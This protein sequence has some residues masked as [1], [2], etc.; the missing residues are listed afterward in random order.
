MAAQVVDPAY[1]GTNVA[2]FDHQILYAQLGS[3]LNHIVV[4]QSCGGQNGWM[5][6][7]GGDIFLHLGNKILQL[8]LLGDHGHVDIAYAE[9]FFG[10]FPVNLPQ[11][12]QGIRPLV[13]G[14]GVREVPD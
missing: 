4:C 10:D 11:Q 1:N 6:S 14:V 9:T 7:G 3:C 5:D 2:G 8:R 13:F 12:H